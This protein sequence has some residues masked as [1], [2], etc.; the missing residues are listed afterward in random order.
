LTLMRAKPPAAFKTR[1]DIARYFGGNAIECLICGRR[2]KRLH[3]HLAAKHGMA[4]DDYKKRHRR[5]PRRLCIYLGRALH[6]PRLI[7]K[8]F[9]DLSRCRL[10]IGQMIPDHVIDIPGSL[11]PKTTLRRDA[12]HQGC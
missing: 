8:Q 12:A 7:T 4:A 10:Q 2:F 6:S 3:T 1:S 11:C 5:A 9:D